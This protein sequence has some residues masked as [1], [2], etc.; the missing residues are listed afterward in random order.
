MAVRN[1][2]EKRSKSKK[3]LD[4]FDLKEG[5]I[6]AQKY[7][8]ENLVGRGWEGEVYLTRELAT[9]IE[10]AAK[11]F[12]PHRN[13][14]NK[15]ANRFAQKLYRAR[16]NPMI[17]QYH[18][19]EHVWLKGIKVTCLISDFVDGELLCDYL[20]RQPLKK[21]HPFIALHIVR[22]IAEGLE[23]LHQEGEY[24]GDLHTGNVF[25]KQSGIHFRIKL[26]DPFDWRDSKQ[27]NIKK[28]VV[29]L[30]KLF[31]ELLGGS[32]SYPQHSLEIKA[33]CC[34]LKASLIIKKFKNAGALRQHLDSFSWGDS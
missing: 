26:I 32:K 23:I 24:H 12:F 3:V 25:I 21:L 14:D 29:D 5:Q 30:V 18:N 2:V 9:G 17:V 31:H 33:I 34:G 1:D 11:F 7:Q 27:L 16:H 8:I 4:S 19:Q 10:R 13:Q 28:D 20:A 15:V 6:V 22:A